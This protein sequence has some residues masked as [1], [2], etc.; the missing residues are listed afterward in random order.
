MG[1]HLKL[2]ATQLKQLTQ[3]QTH[4]L[5]DLNAYSDLPRNIKAT[6]FHNS[7]HTNIIISKLDITPGKCRETS[8][9]FTLPSPHNNLVLRKTTKLLTPYP[10]TFIHQNRHY[11]VTCIQNWHS[12]EPK[13]HHSCKVTY[14][15]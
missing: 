8:N 6:I 9:T 14:I 3:T 12:S 10:M 5:H 11:H 2:H 13:N 15:Q 4:P 1:M 7:V